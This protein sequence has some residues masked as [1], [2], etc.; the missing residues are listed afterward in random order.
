MLLSQILNP[1]DH[2]PARIAKADKNFAK[3]LDFQDIKLAV[4]IRDIHKI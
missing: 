3:T 4:K 1:A 2:H